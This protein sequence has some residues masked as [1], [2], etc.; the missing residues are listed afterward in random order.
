MVLQEYTEYEERKVN[1]AA[2]NGVVSEMIG[3][4]V[5]MKYVPGKIISDVQI[6]DLLTHLHANDTEH[7]IWQITDADVD[8]VKD[9]VVSIF[10]VNLK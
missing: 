4:V 9:Q 5:A 1:N 2:R 6:N 3:M 8:Y 10:G 7:G